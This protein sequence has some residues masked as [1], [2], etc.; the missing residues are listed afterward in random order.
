MQKVVD[1]VSITSFLTY[2][3]SA[4]QQGVQQIIVP[5]ADKI[6]FLQMKNMKQDCIS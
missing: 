6:Q 3:F 5:T 1:S 2:D 4:H